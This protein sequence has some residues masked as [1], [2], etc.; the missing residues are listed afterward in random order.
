MISVK[1]S[2]PG[3]APNA[4]ISQFTG[5]QD[6]IVN[7]CQFFVNA[8]VDNPDVWLVLEGTNPDDAACTIDPNRVAYLAAEPAVPIGYWNNSESRRAYLNQF[9]HIWTFNDVYFRP[10]EWAPPF[11]PWMINANH[12]PSIYAP[13]K[14]DVTWLGSQETIAKKHKLS[15]I[16]SNKAF[17]P[18]HQIRLAF[19]QAAKEH[20]KDRLHWFGNGVHSIECKWDGLVDYEF[21]LALENRYWPGVFTE[22]IVDPYLSL[23]V[24]IY[25]GAPNITDFFPAGSL[26]VI[27]IVNLQSALGRIE[28]LIDGETYGDFLPHLRTAREYALGRF[29]LFQ[30]LSSVARHV[31][32]V[33]PTGSPE[34][35]RISPVA[36]I[37]FASRARRA[38]GYRLERF[39]RGMQ[40]R[41]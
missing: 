22:K 27:D 10:V 12:G 3:A 18:D 6:A 31:V 7:D 24:P 26:E 30:R 40:K 36:A 38:I 37:D 41:I 15:V 19:V 13:H 8:Q 34:R 23:T 39:G 4:D 17:S 14:R 33:S 9:A 32:E 21:T 1:V 29:N 11:L 28:A 25:W 20:F 35:V 2:I 5:R 16:C